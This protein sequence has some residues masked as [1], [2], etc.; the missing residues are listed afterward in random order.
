ML[1]FSARWRPRVLQGAALGRAG[2]AGAPDVPQRLCRPAAARAAAPVGGRP[3][4]MMS[5][6]GGRW[7]VA[8]LAAGSTYALC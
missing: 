5:P 8:V 6:V 4:F 7:D 1:T 3:V 2:V